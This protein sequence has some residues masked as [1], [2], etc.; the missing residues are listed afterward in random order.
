M[1]NL[2]V[3][4]TQYNLILSLAVIENQFNNDNNYLVLFEDF[5]IDER[6]IDN[7][8]KYFLQIDIFTG[9]YYKKEQLW[10]KKVF[11][12][13]YLNKVFKCD[14]NIYDNVFIVEDTT[15]PEQYI[16]KYSYCK[17]NDVNYCCIGDGGYAYFSVDGID[18]TGL[19]K[20]G[21]TM[22][23]RKI[24]FKY[25]FGLG[26]FYT[27]AWCFGSSPLLKT[28]YELYPVYLR[29][30]LQHKTKCEIDGVHFTK[31]VKNLYGYLPSVTIEDNSLIII[32]DKLN[33][34][35]DLELFNTTIE[36]II[37]KARKEKKHIYYKYHPAEKEK[38]SFADEW[39]EIDRNI[40]AEY[41]FS[42]CNAK[43]TWI[44]GIM[45]TALQTASKMGF[46]VT[47]YIKTFKPHRIDVIDFYKQIGIEVK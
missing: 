38:L 45:T 23:L 17:N 34:Y 18:N 25:M 40:S 6:M 2:F 39:V 1:K 46:N 14:A 10:R 35:N 32:L 8:K 30:E 37:N 41:V 31:G 47:S 21:Y 13:F 15:I 44:V 24:V 9:S 3:V 28:I 29:E 22:F 5:N 20:H 19:A 42:C 12:Y 43:T 4:H 7:L 11:R 16:M 27:A 33:V 26:K 36:E